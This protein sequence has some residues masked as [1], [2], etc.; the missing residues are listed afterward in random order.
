[1]RTLLL[2][3]AAVLFSAMTATA[4]SN[5]VAD[6]VATSTTNA[7]ATGGD[8]CMVRTTSD[9]WSSLGLSADQLTKVQDIQAT[10][11]KECVAAKKDKSM[12]DKAGMCKHDAQIKEVLTADQYT[13]WQA[14]CA[15]QPSNTA[16]P[17]STPQTK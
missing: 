11:R 17:Q 12:S 2:T 6:N 1:M 7:S 16:T 9:A 14:W 4:Q 13:K 10:H 15:K 5:L 3:T 8:D